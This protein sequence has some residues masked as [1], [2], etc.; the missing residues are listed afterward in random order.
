M[1][2]KHHQNFNNFRLS[3]AVSFSSFLDRQ[4]PMEVLLIL[5]EFETADTGEIFGCE[6]ICQRRKQWNFGSRLRL[7]SG[8]HKN[9]VSKQ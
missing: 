6:V 7:T 3:F 2:G 9:V 1:E 5:G 4:T 8:N